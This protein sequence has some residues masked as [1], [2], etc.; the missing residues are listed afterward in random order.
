M[1]EC[2]S[3]CSISRSHTHNDPSEGRGGAATD[4][5]HAY[6]TA[7]A[8]FVRAAKIA[9]SG[10]GATARTDQVGCG[11]ES[12][13]SSVNMP[14]RRTT[15]TCTWLQGADGGMLRP[16]LPCMH[17]CRGLRSSRLAL[18]W[19]ADMANLFFIVTA[20][21]AACH[22]RP[23]PNCSHEPT[24]HGN[25]YLYFYP[26]RASAQQVAQGYRQLRRTCQ[27][28]P[29]PQGMHACCVSALSDMRLCVK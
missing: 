12:G 9:R 6:P 24:K 10:S 23:P 2:V 28:V 19:A 26:S 11:H 22:F 3:N 17:Q 5:A 7:S 14:T 8:F 1:T 4:A 15:R 29:S 21:S 13:A 25:L 27:E 18:S 16:P 20:I